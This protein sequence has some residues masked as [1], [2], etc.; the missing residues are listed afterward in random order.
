MK[1]FNFILAYV[2]THSAKFG[3]L[4]A[5]VLCVPCVLRVL[6]PHVPRA[7]HALIPHMSL[8]LCALVPHVPCAL[9]ALVLYVLLCPTCSRALL[10][11]YVSHLHI[12]QIY[13]NALMHLFKAPSFTIN[14][15]Y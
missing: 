6:V 9:R 8:A 11:S 3:A 1:N 4:R 10:G 7:L 12:S 5:L 2:Q 15:Y 13:I 14:L